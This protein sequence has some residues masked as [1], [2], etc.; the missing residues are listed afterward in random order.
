MWNLGFPSDFKILR[1][2]CLNPIRISISIG[3]TLD[4]V[5]NSTNRIGKL[6]FPGSG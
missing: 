5:G 4:L 3:S 1:K 6:V 2:S